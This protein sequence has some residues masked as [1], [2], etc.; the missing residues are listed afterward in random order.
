ML[1]D[2]LRVDV[3]TGRS[4]GLVGILNNAKV[5]AAVSTVKTKSDY[6]YNLHFKALFLLQQLL[7]LMGSVVSDPL[8]KARGT[9]TFGCEVT[10]PTLRLVDKHALCEHQ[11]QIHSR[12]ME[13]FTGSDGRQQV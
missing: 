12:L 13:P 8:T 6:L 3:V 4:R 1:S 11:K 5:A 10:L 2:S 7:R 9:R